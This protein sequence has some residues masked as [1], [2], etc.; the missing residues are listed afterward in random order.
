M[1][2]S[3]KIALVT[4]A[5]QG[6][7]QGIAR[8]LAANG[9]SVAI[10]DLDEMKA[11]QAAK[12]VSA[13]G[14]SANGYALDVTSRGNVLAVVAQVVTDM[15]GLDILVNNAGI[16][17]ARAFLEQTTDSWRA[18]Y[19]V[20][21]FGVFHCCQAV[22]PHMVKK[23]KGNIINISSTAGKRS[24]AWSTHYGSSKH[25]V[26]GI[27]QS[28]AKEFARDEIRV[29]AVCPSLLLTPHW[30]ERSRQIADLEGKEPQQVIAERIERIPLG[31][32]QT[33]EDVGNLVAFLVSEEASSITGQAISVAGGTDL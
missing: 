1:R 30:D 14:G 26:I 15:G 27:T 31:R 22:L 18:I 2:L 28:L 24:N 29:N 25:A 20:N 3:G 7:G 9:A 32:P 10:T 23:R 19:D 33:S 13:D 4:G 6:I 11:Q 8:V 16:G 12:Q 5:G 17:E 21:V